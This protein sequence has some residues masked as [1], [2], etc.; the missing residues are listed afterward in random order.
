MCP[1]NMPH[2]GNDSKPHT[3]TVEEGETMSVLFGILLEDFRTSKIIDRVQPG[4]GGDVP[5]PCRDPVKFHKSYSSDF[6]K[7]CGCD[8]EELSPSEQRAK[9]TAFLFQK[10]STDPKGKHM[11]PADGKRRKTLSWIGFYIT[12]D[13]LPRLVDRVMLAYENS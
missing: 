1:P 2:H 9:L 12:D 3:W 4:V 6:K 10:F 13:E 7:C 5:A 8:F 11:V